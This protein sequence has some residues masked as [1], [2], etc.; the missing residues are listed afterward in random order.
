MKVLIHPNKNK[1]QDFLKTKE[2]INYLIPKEIEVVVSEEMFEDFKDS[3]I[4]CFN[5][6]DYHFNV[7]K[8]YMKEVRTS[9]VSVDYEI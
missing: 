4:S 9:S 6:D 3:N 5:K 8:P 2:I 7:I 1:D